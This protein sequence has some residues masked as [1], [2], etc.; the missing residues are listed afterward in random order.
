M[1]QVPSMFDKVTIRS[2]KLIETKMVK[3][4]DKMDLIKSITSEEI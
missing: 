1:G 2:K 3:N 4:A